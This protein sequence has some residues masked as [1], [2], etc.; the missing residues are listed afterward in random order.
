MTDDTT[1]VWDL[2]IPD[3]ASRGISFA[4]GWMQARDRVLV[5]AAPTR[6]RV[7][8]SSQDGRR[9]AFGDQLER[10]ADTPMTWLRVKG[11]RVT[12]QDGWPTDADIGTLVILPGGEVGTLESWWN[13]EAQQE[14]RWRVEYYNHR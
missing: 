7:E 11:D 9:L 13:D 10:S 3:A 12:R 5:H 2:W 8:V 1:Q 4:R 14:W 6:L